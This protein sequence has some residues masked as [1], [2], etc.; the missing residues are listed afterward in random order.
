MQF[1]N[2]TLTPSSQHRNDKIGETKMTQLRLADTQPT[3]QS[4]V[5]T[6]AGKEE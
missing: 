4:I 2:E 1:T 5:A 3:S 6:A